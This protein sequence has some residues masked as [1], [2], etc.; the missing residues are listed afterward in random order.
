MAARWRTYSRPL[1]NREHERPPLFAATSPRLERVAVGD[2]VGVRDHL[3]TERLELGAKPLDEMSLPIPGIS[4]DDY[5]LAR[6]S[7]LN[8]V[9]LDP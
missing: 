4:S 5:L 9:P 3:G 8:Q 7:L 1:V 6:S 2:G